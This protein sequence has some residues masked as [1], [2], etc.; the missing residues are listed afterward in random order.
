[1]DIW[2]NLPV[3]TEVNDQRQRDEKLAGFFF[4][5][6]REFELAVCIVLSPTMRNSEA[7][8]GIW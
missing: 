1:M 7:Y 3:R 2:A 4:G 5:G 8:S 6:G